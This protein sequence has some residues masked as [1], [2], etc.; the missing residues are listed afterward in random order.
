MKESE[1]WTMD[2]SD[3]IFL[4]S[5]LK[6]CASLVEPRQVIHLYVSYLVLV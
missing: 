3:V 5:L 6:V 2:P 1:C 4:E